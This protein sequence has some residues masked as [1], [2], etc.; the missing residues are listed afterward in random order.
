MFS[1]LH[2][3]KNG[4]LEI[5][6]DPNTTSPVIVAVMFDGGKISC[7]FSHVTGGFK[8]VDPHCKDPK[9]GTFLFSDSGIEN[10]QSHIHCF[11]VKVCFAKDTKQLYHLEFDDFFAFLRE[12]EIEKGR[13]IKFVFP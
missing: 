2:V 11:P 13:R 10:V 1:G 3:A 8:Q 12:Y 7:F 4:L 5:I 9:K 6:D